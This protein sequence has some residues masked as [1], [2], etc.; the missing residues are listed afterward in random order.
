MADLAGSELAAQVPWRSLR[1]DWRW[2]RVI[3]PSCLNAWE[4]R[5]VNHEK[6]KQ[7]EESNHESQSQTMGERLPRSAQG[8]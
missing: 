5:Q 2:E 3:L 7:N 4:G 8:T 1:L 6:V